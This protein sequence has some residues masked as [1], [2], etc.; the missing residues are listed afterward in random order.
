M[1][2]PS[3]PQSYR[4]ARGA[5]S[6]IRLTSL[7]RRPGFARPAPRPIGTL[8]TSVEARLPHSAPGALASQIS[9]RVISQRASGSGSSAGAVASRA[10]GK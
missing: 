5:A 8:Y 2:W 3:T 4:M 9:S 10:R 1:I 7:A 6:A